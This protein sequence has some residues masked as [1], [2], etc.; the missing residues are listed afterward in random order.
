VSVPRGGTILLA[1]LRSVVK[2]SSISIPALFPE[3]EAL[4][5]DVCSSSA[6]VFAV[7]CWLRL[8]RH[9]WTLRLTRDRLFLQCPSCGS[10][11]PGWTFTEAPPRLRIAGH[12]RRHIGWP[13]SSRSSGRLA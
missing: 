12:P 9:A 7:H 11:T 8:R 5:V 2:P 4:C 6:A 1:R 3:Q 13:T 10:Q